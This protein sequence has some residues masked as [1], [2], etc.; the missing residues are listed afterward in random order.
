[1]GGEW[2]DR[3][4]TDAELKAHPGSLWLYDDGKR[5]PIVYHCSPGG[6]YHYNG[7]KYPPCA[8]V[9]QSKY[10]FPWEH[11]LEYGGRWRPLTPRGDDAPWPVVTEGS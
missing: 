7:E 2:R 11:L 8:W 6:T 10:D 5:N 4:P 9:E 3:A 1:M